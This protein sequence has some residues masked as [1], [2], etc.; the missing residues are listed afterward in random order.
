MSLLEKVKKR[1]REL[2]V[3]FEDVQLSP[4]PDKKIMVVIDGKKIHFGAKNS[5]SYLEQRNDKKRDAY[6][7]RHSAIKLKDGT[8]AIDNPYSPAWLSFYALWM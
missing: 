2:D 4:K 1:L 7:A 5:T 3:P 8:R 6:I